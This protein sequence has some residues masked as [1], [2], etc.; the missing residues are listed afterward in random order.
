MANL[1]S[2]VT[3][4]RGVGPSTATRLNRLGI[5]T[6]ADLLSH[7][8]TRHEDLTHVTTVA[9]LRSNTTAVLRGRL[10]LIKARRGFRRRRMSIT[11]GLFEDGSGSI[12]LVWFNQQYL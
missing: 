6:I 1:T 4:L 5:R 7:Y 10:Q 11:E 9:G 12:R 8:P 2:P 3:D